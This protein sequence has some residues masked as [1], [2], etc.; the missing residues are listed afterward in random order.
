[1]ADALD[2]AAR[3]WPNEPR[4][5]LLVRLVK[6]GSASLEQTRSETIRSCVEAVDASSGKYDDAFDSNY[7][8]DLRRGWPE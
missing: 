4:S 2:I 5:K 8:A 1:M 3:R 6:A 7:L